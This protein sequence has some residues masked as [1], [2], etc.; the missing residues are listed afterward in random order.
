MEKTTYELAD[1]GTRAIAAIIDG[2]IL[3]IVTTALYGMGGMGGS[4]L[5]LLIQVGYQW[6]FWTRNDGQT[7]GKS[8]MGIKV[9]KTD[10]TP[11]SD[12]DAIVRAIGYW[13]SGVVLL[14]GFIWAIFDEENQTWHDKLASTYVV[15]AQ[16]KSVDV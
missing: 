4:S 13:V 15:I 10:G 2:I 7:P 3:G 16:S 9:I 14:L 5:S 11:I 12:G 6:Y 1:I 8:V